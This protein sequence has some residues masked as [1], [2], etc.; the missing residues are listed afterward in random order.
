MAV[1]A[2]E[3]RGARLSPSRE[4]LS[5]HAQ[6]ATATVIYGPDSFVPLSGTLTTSL[7]EWD[8]PF[9]FRDRCLRG[10]GHEDDGA[11]DWV[12][13]E[14]SRTTAGRREKTDRTRGK[15]DAATKKSGFVL[16]LRKK[17][18]ASPLPVPLSSPELL[19][20]LSGRR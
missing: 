9:L 10:H 19:L 1:A 20:L 2:D 12:N 4:P 17:E 7:P 15:V 14:R 18:T 3:S 13:R 6:P 16:V 11:G 8:R 5:T